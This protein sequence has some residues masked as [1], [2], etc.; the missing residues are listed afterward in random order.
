MLAVLYQGSR[1]GLICSGYII[2]A[3]SLIGLA[4]LQGLEFAVGTPHAVI[5]TDQAGR[6]RHQHDGCGTVTS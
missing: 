6:G 4:I 3:I 2:I 1:W 5:G